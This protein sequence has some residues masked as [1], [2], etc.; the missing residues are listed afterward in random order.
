[1]VVT[2]SGDIDTSQPSLQ[3]AIVATTPTGAA[4]LRQ[5]VPSR[6]RILV[7]DGGDGVVRF[8]DVVKHL[9]E[10][11][12]RTLLAEGGPSLFAR[13]VSERVVDELFVTL[14]PTLFGRYAHDGRKALTDGLDLAGT[15]LDLLSIRQHRSHLFLRYAI[16]RIHG[17]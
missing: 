15:S 1:V 13:L 11:G 5:R 10:E 8:A 16:R 3:D 7:C 9:H 6:A 4:R 17:D 2:G 12:L 14:S